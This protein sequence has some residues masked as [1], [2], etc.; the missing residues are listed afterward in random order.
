[1]AEAAAADGRIVWDKFK[2]GNT[3]GKG[4]F[5]FV[6]IGRHVKSNKA[7]A[8]KFIKKKA[9]SQREMENQRK[10]IDNEIT[11]LKKVNHKNVLKLNAYNL[12]CEYPEKN[13]STLDTIMLVLELATGGELFDIL[14]YASKLEPTLA[15][16]YFLQLMSG[17]KAI[18]DAG[19]CHRD[20]KPQNLLLDHNYQ[21]KICDFGLAKVLQKVPQGRLQI[22]QTEFVGTQ[23][24]Q[25]PEVLLKRPY[26]NRCDVFACGVI[27]FILLSGY[28]PFETA[29]GKDRWYRKLCRR[30]TAGFWEMHRDCLPD[31]ADKEDLKDLICK[32]L[33]YQ[34]NE[35]L[36]VEGSMAHTWAQGEVLDDDTLRKTMITKHQAAVRKKKNSPEAQKM[37]ENCSAQLRGIA[38]D[39]PP[40]P[41][42][43]YTTMPK[44]TTYLI[45]SS[46]YPQPNND[47]DAKEINEHR[48]E[49]SNVLDVFK[50]V[51][52]DKGG[53]ATQAGR[54][55]GGD[56]W[57]IT[58]IVSAGENG[59]AELSCRLMQAT[60]QGQQR[61]VFT[62]SVNTDNRKSKPG[63]K[64]KSLRK[65][66]VSAVESALLPVWDVDAFT[67]GEEEE[68]VAGAY[69]YESEFA[70]MEAASVPTVE[71]TA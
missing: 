33:S 21:L 55:A 28:P 3:L 25:A 4:G 29:D 45:D 57:N 19:I 1:M 44:A 15:R 14:F 46:R 35:R 63:S 42:A 18:Q 7:F 54:N 16:T 69:D 40:L 37:L 70:A 22:M 20:L 59:S 58:G 39:F 8:L 10:E 50:K 52:T 67:W 6:K 23:G 65:A 5:G 11:S 66:M 30:D 34:P 62:F 38:G 68:E 43:L 13:G 56:F 31:T 26:T 49:L 2:L 12:N 32:M 17:L 36:D 53:N 61:Y 24:Y 9:G 47:A 27:L 51:I 60:V 71:V 41:P 64:K 48:G